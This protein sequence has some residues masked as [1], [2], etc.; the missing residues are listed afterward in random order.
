MKP[1]HGQLLK[2]LR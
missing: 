2:Q 1:L